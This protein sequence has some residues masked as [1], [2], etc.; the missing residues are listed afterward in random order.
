MNPPGN[1]FY[2]LLQ[3]PPP[4]LLS[5]QPT[6]TLVPSN[7]ALVTCVAAPTASW[8]SR[9]AETV[10]VLL[11]FVPTALSTDPYTEN[12][13]EVR[14]PNQMPLLASAAEDVTF[15]LV[16]PR[17]GEAPK[18]WLPIQR[19]TPPDHPQPLA[20]WPPPFTRPRIARGSGLRQKAEESSPSGVSA[21]IALPPS[22]PAS[23]PGHALPEPEATSLP[24]SAE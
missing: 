7:S 13:A 10:H 3:S 16:S 2:I 18:A 23:H 9:K 21:V 20:L 17:S 12:V 14:P 5:S 22:Q 11:I 6:L 19:Q 15:P 4:Q 8:S 1:C 24:F